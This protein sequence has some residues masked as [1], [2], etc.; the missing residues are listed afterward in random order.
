MYKHILKRDINAV[1]STDCNYKVSNQV[2]DNFELSNIVPYVAFWD[3]QLD[4]QVE[5][6]MLKITDEIHWRLPWLY[7]EFSYCVST[8]DP[9]CV[10]DKKVI[11]KQPDLRITNNSSSVRVEKTFI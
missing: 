6:F 3:S 7:L 2:E 10:G 5:I 1:D 8:D 9:I 4:R 11:I